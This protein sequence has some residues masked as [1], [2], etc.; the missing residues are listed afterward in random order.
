MQEIKAPKRGMSTSSILVAEWT[1]KDGEK[2][3]KGSEIVV[4]EYEKT[5]YVVEAEI[6][7]YLHIIVHEGQEVAIGSIIG[8][9]TE[10][11]EEIKEYK[12]YDSQPLSSVDSKENEVN[13]KEELSKENKNNMGSS[14]SSIKE[15][16][17]TP[18]ARRLLKKNNLKIEDIF[19]SDPGGTI[20]KEDILK[21][22]NEQYNKKQ[23]LDSNIVD[24]KRMKEIKPLIGI[25]KR[26][27]E[28]MTRSL[29]I[30]AQ[31]T[32]MGEIDMTE[33]KKIRNALLEREKDWCTRITFTDLF[34]YL[35]SRQLKNHPI[36][37]SSLIDNE[38]KLWD[39]INI[40]VATSIEGG[41]VVP[42][43]K[44]TERK[45]LIELSKELKKLVNRSREGQLQIEDIIGGT[46]TISNLGSHSGV[47][48]R[49]ETVII[50]PPEAA[51]LG[52]GG[53]SDRVVAHDGK[54]AIK[55]IQTYY[56]TYDH[57][58]IDGLNANNFMLDVKNAFENPSL[59]I[60]L[61]L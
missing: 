47:G 11:I 34:I 56:F 40:G 27:A 57:R 10:T 8:I 29:S 6:T 39:S 4:L 52:T 2:I 1:A 49:F 28:N 37:N 46:F 59:Y 26:I 32:L 3:T 45:S 5:T 18:A 15:V 7:G 17:I 33:M 22:I 9:I 43:L 24:G 60:D 12:S 44:D 23:S 55:P 48:Y 35:I 19:G 20:L 61:N 50:N 42:V 41:L 36:I 58:I 51:I 53:I 25:R 38:I 31:V 21:L 13:N 54:I 30:S 14:E 16:R